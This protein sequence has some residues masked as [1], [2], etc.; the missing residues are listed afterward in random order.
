MI[1]IRVPVVSSIQ[2]MAD[3]V[4][5][6][7]SSLHPGSSAAAEL[8]RARTL[9]IVDISPPSPSQHPKASLWSLDPSQQQALEH[10][11]VVLGDATVL[12]PLLLTRAN[13]LPVHQQQLLSRVQ[14]VQATFA[15]VEAF[16]RL[17]AASPS[18]T[19]TN[20]TSACKPVFTLTRAGGVLPVAMA[21]YVLGCVCVYRG[22]ALLLA[23]IVACATHGRMHGCACNQPAGSSRWSASSSTPKSSRNRA[24]TRLERSSTGRSARL[25]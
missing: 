21:Q 3:A 24:C 1:P 19:L 7:L 2:G 9:E 15:G 17:L 18:H 22:G 25:L 4:R 16:E 11:H 14:W 13:A 6:R 20:V 23:S 12:A 8:F 5:Q 10:A